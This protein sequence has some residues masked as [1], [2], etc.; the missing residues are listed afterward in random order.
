VAQVAYIS[1]AIDRGSYSPWMQLGLG[2]LGAV[3]GSAAD[4]PAVEQY[5]HRYAG[6]RGAPAASTHMP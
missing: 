1:R 6:R 5:L 3:I 2:V 4:R